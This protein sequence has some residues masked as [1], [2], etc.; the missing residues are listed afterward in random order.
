MIRAD[1]RVLG[2]GCAAALAIA[3]CG[4]SGKSSSSSTPSPAPGASVNASSGGQSAVS[5][6][7]AAVAVATKRA[8]KLGEILDAGPKKLT[9]Y[10]FE[11]DKQGQ[12]ACQGACAQAWPP[13]TTS[14]APHA[15]GGALASD[16]G[17]ITRPDGTKQLTYRGHPLYYF[18]KDKD[19][20]DAY[21]EG[22]NAFGGGW[23]A[24]NAKG[25]KV[26]LS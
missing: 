26:D 17:V 19:A 24:L 16:L 18:M 21:G 9:V 6:G 11:A 13:V 2:V 22:V 3:G 4:S 15:M 25:A 8:G 1:V 12:S 10:L 7:Q 23:Y 14:G 5:A 20:G